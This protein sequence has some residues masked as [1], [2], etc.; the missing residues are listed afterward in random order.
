[1]FLLGSTSPVSTTAA[2]VL[3]QTPALGRGT[4]QGH[5]HPEELPGCGARS[6]G[7]VLS[8]GPARS[9]STGASLWPFE[10]HV[11][12]AYSLSEYS[13]RPSAPPNLAGALGQL[14]IL[15]SLLWLRFSDAVELFHFLQSCWM[16]SRESSKRH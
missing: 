14:Y 13:G 12:L 1:M 10:G 11:T 16:L 3:P 7:S 6:V 15:S 2:H 8:P 9:V 5:D 4:V